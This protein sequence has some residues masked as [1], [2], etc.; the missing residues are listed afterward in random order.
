MKMKLHFVFVVM[1]LNILC[2]GAAQADHCRVFLLGGQSN[3]AGRAPVSDLPTSPVNLQNPQDDVLFYYNSSLTTLRPGSGA[4]FGPE[5]TFGRTIADEFPAETF[6]LIKYA[7][8][9]TSLVDEWDPIS[10]GDY[11]TF[12]SKVTNGLSALTNA[13]HTYEIVGM[14]WTQGERDAKENRTTP[15]YQADLNEFIADIRTRYGANLPFFISRLS[16]GQTNMTSTQLTNIRTAQENVAASDAHAW[17]IDTDSMGIKSDYLHFDAAGQI[18]LGQAFGNTFIAN[19]SFGQDPELPSVDAGVDMITWSGNT[20]QLDPNVINNDVT[21]LVYYWSADPVDGVVFSDEY[22]QAPTVTITKTT[23]NPS[24]VTLTLAVNNVGSSNDDVIDTMTIDVYD[25]AC[26]AALLGFDE[27]TNHPTDI[28]GN[29]VTGIEDLAE[30][31]SNWL[32]GNGLSEPQPK[33]APGPSPILPESILAYYS[34]DSDFKDASANGNDLTIAAGTPTIT[35]ESGEFVYGGALDI[36]STI[37]SAEYLNLTAP[38]TFATGDAWSISFWARRRPNTDDRS[39][40]VLGDSG[41][42]TDFIWL[43]NNPDQVQG[44]RF[45]NSSNQNANYGGFPDDNLFHHWVVVS[46]GAGNITSYRD[47]KAQVPV[48]ITGNFSITSVAHA[49]SST[50]QSMDGQIDELYIFSEAI[51]VPTVDALYNNTLLGTGSNSVDAGVDMVTWSG[52]AVQLNPNFAEG[53]NP[54]S[55]NWTADPADG[56]IF[57]DE[58][59]EAPT[60]T[61]TKYTDNP[62]VVVLTLTADDGTAPQSDSLEIDV[63]DDACQAGIA[64]GAMLDVT[65]FNLDCI[66]NLEDLAE[67]SASWLE[68]YKLQTYQPKP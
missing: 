59:A 34:F 51:D 4:D 16:S 60:V 43:S 67:M 12:R 48:S 30:L 35:S 50:V 41:N 3:M 5:V 21:E 32:K 18:S 33:S 55:F 49:Y 64:L 47:N 54:T 20:V 57:S 7:R 26:L 62:S 63:Y 9:G 1:A 31:A 6:A 27:W 28:S 2:I 10:G 38:I 58:N 36:D 37:S 45:R 44:L 24:V 13:G 66:T 61:I 52:Q 68:D 15:Q 42:Q 25:D 8:G 23:D 65:D 39:G 19:Y 56:V 40:M 22:A 46:D 29:C 53:Y 11:S 14:L 17:M